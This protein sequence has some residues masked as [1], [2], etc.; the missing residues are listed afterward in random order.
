MIPR[1]KKG[2]IVCKS[3]ADIFTRKYGVTYDVIRNVPLLAP[4][5]EIERKEKT[6]LYQGAINKGRGLDK[7]IEAMQN[8]QGILWICGEG[9]FMTEIKSA[10]KK[11]NV[12][13]KII[14]WG[15]LNPEELKKKTRSAYMAI[16]PFERQGL[17]QYLS[18]SNK[19]FDYIHAALPQVTLNYPEYSHINKEIE[20]ALLIDDLEPDTIAA[21]VNKLFSDMELYTRLK[22]NCEIARKS[23][24]WQQEEK[25]LL[26]FYQQL[27]HE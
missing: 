17:N 7:L 27:F 8:I 3:I 13:E 22:N 15:M 5:Q 14:F 10:V 21:S 24:N 4:L 26:A 25:I 2:Y 11:Y 6:L 19:F 16:N 1:F 12:S 23:F 9:N 20:V 18:L